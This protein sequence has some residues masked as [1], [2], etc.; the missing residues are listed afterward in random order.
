MQLQ[1]VDPPSQVIDSFR[2]VQAARADL[3][4][5]QN[6]AQTYANR[7]VPEARGRAAQITQDAEAYREQTVA[8]AKGQTSRFLQV[9]DQYKKAPDVTR[10]RMYLET[11]ERVLGGTEKIDHRY[12]PQPTSGVVPYLPLTELPRRAAAAAAARRLPE[13]ANETRV[14]PAASS[15]LSSSWRSCIVAYGTLFTVNQTQ[16]ALVVR[17][18]EPVRVITEPGLNVKMPFID[19]VIYVDKR[20]LDLESPAQEVIA[21]DQKRLV[22]D[23]FARYRINDPLKFYQTVGETGANSQLAIL[24]NSALRRVLG[25]ATLTEVVRDVRDAADGARARAARHEAQPFGIQVVDVRIR[26]ADLPEQNSQAVYQRMQT[27]RQREAAEFRA[28]GSQKSQEIRARADRDVTVLLAEA[29]SQAEQTRGEGDSERNRIFADAYQPRSR[30]LRFLPLD[31][32]L[33]RGLQHGDT[34]LVL[35]PD[36]DFFR[37]FVDPSGKPR[38]AR[39]PGRRRQHRQPRPTPDRCRSPARSRRSPGASQAMSDFLAAI[40]SFFV[41]EGMLFAGLSAGRQAMAA[42][43]GM[44]DSRC[45]SRASFRRSSASR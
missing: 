38:E 9:Y 7:V 3:E 18:G 17:L 24:L 28:Q 27:E 42:A 43:L 44:P 40:G 33:R 36:S 5:A 12:R 22:V 35:R 32:G 34:R 15:P 30:F 10:Q 37:Y 20:I 39:R 19:S 4:R 8:E 14:L 16:Q 2:D 1:K 41:I 11:M 13:P 25:E 31:A 45:A 21:S 26:R 23:A 29:N 6:E